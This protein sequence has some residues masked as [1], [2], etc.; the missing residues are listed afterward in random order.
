M[1]NRPALSPAPGR[2]PGR[3]SAQ[4][5][6]SYF[7]SHGGGPWPWMAEMHGAMAPLAAVAV[8]G[9]RLGAT[10]ASGMKAFGAGER[11]RAPNAS[12]TYQPYRPP[13]ARM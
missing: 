11:L 3:A 9:C 6:P 5:L 10:L 8:G 7:I 13:E 4:R 2:A 12:P 1:N